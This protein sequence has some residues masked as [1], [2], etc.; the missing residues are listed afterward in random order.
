MNN[1]LVTRA[2]NGDTAA[3]EQLVCEYEKRVYN[4]A[5]KMSRNPEDALDLSQDIFIRIYKSLPLFKGDS[6]FSTWVYSIAS[7]ACI[8]YTRRERRKSRLEFLP[9]DEAIPP[10]D[11]RYQ[12]ELEY[13]KTALRE[14]ISRALDELSPEHR[15]II[16]LREL[17]GLSYDEIADTLD[18]EHGTVKSRISRARQKLCAL[19]GNNSAKSSSKKKKER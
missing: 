15:E 16:V 3:F 11:F 4:L 1:D 9:L 2:Q 18:I 6:S 10:P 19:L 13:E 17:N 12:P 8:D 14:S 5:L 7:N